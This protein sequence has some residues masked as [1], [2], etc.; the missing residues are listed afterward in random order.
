MFHRFE[1]ECEWSEIGWGQRFMVSTLLYTKLH[2][3]TWI[4][5]FI[6]TLKMLVRWRFVFHY[7]IKLAGN[8]SLL[9]SNW[10]GFVLNMRKIDHHL[11]RQIVP[12]KMMSNLH[13]IAINHKSHTIQNWRSEKK[14]QKWSYWNPELSRVAQFK[15]NGNEFKCEKG[16]TYYRHASIREYKIKFARCLTSSS[17]K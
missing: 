7:S 16:A 6:H 9:R 11:N 15:S 17:S 5:K 14:K 10:V 4:T 2:I 1:C 8:L 13:L 3:G 12:M